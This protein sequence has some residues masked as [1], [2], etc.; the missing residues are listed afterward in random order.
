MANFS[1]VVRPVDGGRA[2]PLVL[3][4]MPDTLRNGMQV[5]ATG[6]VTADAVS[7]DA[8]SITIIAASR[9]RNRRP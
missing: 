2:T 6:S 1:Y 5:I 9:R 4:L 3:D 7:L 8:T